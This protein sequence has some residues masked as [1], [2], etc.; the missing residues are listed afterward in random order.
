M[1]VESAGWDKDVLSAASLPDC[2][3]RKYSDQKVMT[4]DA[5]PFI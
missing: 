5:V 1:R 4:M 3:G 2:S